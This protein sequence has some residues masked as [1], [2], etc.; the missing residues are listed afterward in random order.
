MSRRIVLR[1][2]LVAAVLASLASVGTAHALD[3]GP[4][5]KVRDG[6]R[7][8]RDGDLEGALQR[9]TEAQVDLP[10]SPILHYNIGNIFYRQEDYARAMDEYRL[11]AAADDAEIAT[12]ARFNMGN[13]HFKLQ[14]YPNAVERYTDVLREVPTDVDAK[15]NLEL[16]LQA[17]QQEPPPEEQGGGESEEGEEP[18]DP[19]E[20]QQP[21]PQD[22]EEGEGSP[23]EGQEPQ[24]QP[25]PEESED[26]GSGGQPQPSP[27]EE[28]EGQ[29]QQPQTM[30]AAPLPMQEAERI[31][32]ALKEQEKENM[33]KALRVPRRGKGTGKDW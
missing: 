19:S 32:D 31:L 24:P 20:E 8:Y 6:N 27:G 7:L 29:D 12:R 10:D 11:A 25:E 33:K 16:A 23:D 15:R 30:D 22:P 21:G 2:V 14:D 4:A 3:R 1:S 5:E 13:A 17:L 28:A 9:Y 26:P 18:P